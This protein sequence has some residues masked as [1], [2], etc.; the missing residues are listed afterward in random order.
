ML[1]EVGRRVWSSGFRRPGADF[2]AKSQAP[3]SQRRQDDLFQARLDQII[4]AG[5]ELVRLAAPACSTGSSSAASSATFVCP[6]A[7]LPT[8]AP[9]PPLH[10]AEYPAL[11]DGTYFTTGCI[12]VP[13]RIFVVYFL[14]GS[15]IMFLHDLFG[16]A[17]SA[18][19]L[20]TRLMPER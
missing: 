15:A 5:H 16:T 8:G 20:C 2:L 9:G 19:A 6:V 1:K 4:D 14:A 12:K 18:M 17:G 10:A 11:P 3:D 7:V 13:G